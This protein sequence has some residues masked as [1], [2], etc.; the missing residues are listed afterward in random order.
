[1][2]KDLGL[3]CM[4]GPVWY[5]LTSTYGPRF[6]GR[7]DLRERTEIYNIV[8]VT[9]PFYR[10][11]TRELKREILDWI[12]TV[13]TQ[14]SPGDQIVVILIGHGQADTANVVLNSQAGKEYLTKTE[15]SQTLS[16]LRSML[17]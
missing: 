7:D 8:E 17:V 15:I 12:Q 16:S 14:T 1:M 5:R 2:T 13:S 9:T 11:V 4:S 6:F 3:T 10:L